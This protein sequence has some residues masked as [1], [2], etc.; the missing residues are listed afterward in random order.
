MNNLDDLRKDVEI[1]LILEEYLEV[2]VQVFSTKDSNGD[3]LVDRRYILGKVIYR[4]G[5]ARYE[6]GDDSSESDL[7]SGA[8]DNLEL[9]FN[10]EH[11]DIKTNENIVRISLKEGV[12]FARRLGG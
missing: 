10:P 2:S 5:E 12:T 7:I 11:Y 6:R 9:C 8:V 1:G 4:D 3:T